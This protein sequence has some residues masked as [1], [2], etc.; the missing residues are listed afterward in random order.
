LLYQDIYC[1][2]VP[3]GD[4]QSCHASVLAV[5]CQE[6]LLFMFGICLNNATLT[7]TIVLGVTTI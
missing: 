3:T 1:T 5:S 2:D 4:L 7:L 6:E